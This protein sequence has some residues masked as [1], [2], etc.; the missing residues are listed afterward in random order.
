MQCQWSN[1]DNIF[2]IADTSEG[3]NGLRGLSSLIGYRNQNRF[4]FFFLQEDDRSFFFSSSTSEPFFCFYTCKRHI[5]NARNINSPPLTWNCLYSTS[6]MSS[7]NI[8]NQNMP[9]LKLH[10]VRHSL[11]AQWQRCL[12][13]FLPFP[14]LTYKKS[15]EPTQKR[16]MA[17]HLIRFWNNNAAW[18]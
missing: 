13:A 7:R 4:F 8:Q 6:W 2:L 16:Q 5:I 14:V 1:Y 3:M 10:A 18:R 9:R 11:D 15:P 17:S 12:Q